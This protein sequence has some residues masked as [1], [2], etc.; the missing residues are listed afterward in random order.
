MKVSIFRIVELDAYLV[1]I[2]VL[3][4]GLRPYTVVGWL[5]GPYL[6][7]IAATRPENL[8]AQRH[9][10]TVLTLILFFLTLTEIRPFLLCL[11]LLALSIRSPT[12][13][14]P[15]TIWISTSL[16]VTVFIT[17]ILSKNGYTLVVG[18]ILFALNWMFLI[19]IHL[20]IDND[21]NFLPIR[22][23]VA[24]NRLPMVLLPHPFLF[25]PHLFL[26]TPF[27]VLFFPCFGMKSPPHALSLRFLLPFSFSDCF[28]A[29]SPPRRRPPFVLV[30]FQWSLQSLHITP[31]QPQL[32]LYLLFLNCLLVSQYLP[33][34]SLTLLP[35]KFWRTHASVSGLSSS[36]PW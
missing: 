20:R 6:W 4:Y 30:P 9:P 35:P 10:L 12:W 34:R 1:G 3:V 32:G 31:P 24:Q 26:R 22:T 33:L 2:A 18:F 13:N 5:N 15:F 17:G 29:Y 14:V 19:R 7:L 36:V 21:T 28:P 11:L 23:L 16:G 27:L 25:G 8:W